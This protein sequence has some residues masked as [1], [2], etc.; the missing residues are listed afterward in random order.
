MPGQD[1]VRRYTLYTRIDPLVNAVLDTVLVGA[2]HLH[3]GRRGCP[4]HPS[5][6][7]GCAADAMAAPNV[8]NRQSNEIIVRQHAAPDR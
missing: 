6:T 4:K 8:G 7:R 1:A 3:D 2:T 5:L